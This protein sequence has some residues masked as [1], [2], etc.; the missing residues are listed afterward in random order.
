ME[1]HCYTRCGI[2]YVFGSDAPENIFL[3]RGETTEP[4]QIYLQINP[5]ALRWFCIKQ[6]EQEQQEPL[7]PIPEPAFAEPVFQL[8]LSSN[9]SERND[10]DRTL[11]TCGYLPLP[12]VKDRNAYG[13]RLEYPKLH[14][15]GGS[16]LFGALF[17]D[18][19]FDLRHSRVFE[20]C[21]FAADFDTGLLGH[22]LAN[23]IHD[24]AEYRWNRKLYRDVCGRDGGEQARKLISAEGEWLNA[25]MEPEAQVLFKEAGDW[26][27]PIEDEV[28]RVVFDSGGDGGADACGNAGLWRKIINYQKCLH[29]P[30]LVVGK[31]EN[32]RRVDLYRRVA[33][34]FLA[35]YDLDAAAATQVLH[36]FHVGRDVEDSGD[37][38]KFRKIL[39]KGL[40][41]LASLP[42]FARDV[43]NKQIIPPIQH[44]TGPLRQR[45]P[46]WLVAKG[47]K[48]PRLWILKAFK[49]ISP[50]LAKVKAGASGIAKHVET[51]VDKSRVFLSVRIR[52]LLYIGVSAASY[53]L[54]YHP[55]TRVVT[56][57]LVF[58]ACAYVMGVCG[59]YDGVTHVWAKLLVVYVVNILPVLF[60]LLAI[61]CFC[62]WARLKGRFVRHLRNA[63]LVVR[64]GLPRLFFA[65]SGAW[66]MFYSEGFWSLNVMVGPHDVLF[67]GI[68]VLMISLVFT[69]VKTYNM[70]GDAVRAVGRSFL[71][72]GMALLISLGV[73][74]V[75]MSN[76]AGAAIE[77]KI[78][79]SKEP[80]LA[81]ANYVETAK[82]TLGTNCFLEILPGADIAAPYPHL[83]EQTRV[84]G[85]LRAAYILEP[86]YNECGAWTAFL[87]HLA[88]VK[89][90]PAMLL[91]YSC[92]AVFFGLFLQLIFGDKE[93][94]ES[95]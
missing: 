82:S 34:W 51:A 57:L 90:F 63:L 31:G 14:A 8:T 70:T 56:I 61:A 45:L 40:T 58:V 7:R 28:R 47:E 16:L 78:N 27:D 89:I 39:G 37:N 87:R 48:S 4:P 18:F 3:Y 29:Q 55:V 62:L 44:K 35:R 22:P 68:P 41:W 52:R 75:L 46:E 85:R 36:L 12:D 94:T 81:Y 66:M 53:P 33:G 9:L 2:E 30:W 83:I 72:S 26:F 84:L 86:E 93:M 71:M 10:F 43:F 5:D 67:V 11:A 88:S 21:S 95:L 59:L 6:K 73:G 76:F 92:Y 60:L 24:K 17:L 74:T 64:L 1:G 42:G 38:R 19:L 23:A 65:I 80:W 54:P 13:F 77:G 49:C 25:C 32:E 20:C 79:D 15:E 50:C 91:Y 69:M